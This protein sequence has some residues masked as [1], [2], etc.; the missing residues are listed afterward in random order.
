MDGAGDRAYA[1]VA[2]LTASFALF[3]AGGCYPALSGA[4]DGCVQDTSFECPLDLVSFSCAGSARPDQNPNFS[5]GVQG[6]VCTDQGVLQP[7]QERFCCTSGTTS[8]AY[9]PNAVCPATTYG[10]SCLGT[11][12]PD[13][14]D[15]TLSCGQGI[16]SGGLFVYCCGT[17]ATPACAKDTNI[18][19]ATGTT[20]FR[21]TGPGLPNEGELG[22][23][24]S[25]SDAP[26]LCSL[27]VPQANGATAFCC[28][29]P[30][31]E[32][33][34]ATCLQDQEVTGCPSGSYGFSCAGTDTPDEDYPRMSCTQ[35]GVHG[36]DEQGVAATL[37][38]CS[39]MQQ[40]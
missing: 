25:R 27:P 1:G 19:C 2:A 30:T 26:L 5:Q 21:C 31:D 16:A 23:D 24:Q 17:E 33:T 40:K 37:Y 6:I 4:D 29:T 3:G 39:Y 35:P 7:G 11:N 34:G 15:P 9:D 28:F 12:R 20:G 32:P 22:V 36:A 14:F 18:S 8:C 13:A 38:C 10:Y